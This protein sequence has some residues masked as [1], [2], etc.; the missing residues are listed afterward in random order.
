MAPD[1]PADRP[2]EPLGNQRHEQFAV[3][4]AAN[5]NAAEA[6]RHA[7]GK[8]SH[9]DGNGSKWLK[10]GSIA[11]RIEWLRAAAERRAAEKTNE[12]NRTAILTVCEKREILAGIA[13]GEIANN[14]PD[15]KTIR[16]SD[17]VAAIR[18]DNDLAAE[19]AE[20]AS[21]AAVVTIVRNWEVV[22]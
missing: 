13:R 2:M 10:K 16:A 3:R 4:Y 15:G 9:A 7:G 21:R 18:A 20:A 1:G 6:W 8:G 19:G 17:M 11:A 14:S 5:G 12:A 22:R